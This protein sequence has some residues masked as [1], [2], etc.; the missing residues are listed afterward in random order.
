MGV[1][2]G[3]TP[4]SPRGRS[5]GM[6]FDS[7]AIT[8]P[9]RNG[10]QKRI[11]IRCGG[12][13]IVSLSRARI[14]FSCGHDG[15][16]RFPRTRADRPQGSRRDLLT[17]GLPHVLIIDSAHGLRVQDVSR[18]PRQQEVLF[19]ADTAFRVVRRWTPQS[20]V[21]YIHMQEID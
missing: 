7:G 21:T 9:V 16:R 20:A 14:P 8:D 6:A 5:P 12:G 15:H 19:A 3:G 4:P 11:M 10:P 2:P 18:R 13:T 1:A 17:T